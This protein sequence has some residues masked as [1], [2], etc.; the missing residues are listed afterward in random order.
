[1]DD[2]DTINLVLLALRLIIGLGLAMHGYAKI[3]RGGRLEGTGG[4]FDS[5]GMRP[6]HVHARLAAFTEIGAGLLMAV[7]FLTPSRPPASSA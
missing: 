3:F 1:M 6:G 7:G 4:W 5:M 2:L